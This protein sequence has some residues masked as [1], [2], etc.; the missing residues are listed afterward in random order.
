MGS[1]I[2][3]KERRQDF[4]SL[5]F[6]VEDIHLIV[7]LSVLFNACIKLGVVTN[8]FPYLVPHLQK[9][10]AEHVQGYSVAHPE[11]RVRDISKACSYSNS[12]VWNILHTT[13]GHRT[14]PLR[15]KEDTEDVSSELANG[16]YRLPFLD[17]TSIT[18]LLSDLE[19]FLETGSAGRRQGQGRRGA[20]TPNEYRYLVLTARRHRKMNATLLQ[21]H[22]RSA[23][24]TTVSTQTVRNRLHGVGMYADRPIVCVRLTSRHRPV[25]WEW[26]TEHVNWRRNEWS[27]S[28]F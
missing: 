21:Q 1:V 5:N 16:D 4:M 19:P 26:A 15:V 11:S 24:G 27:N 9:I 25:R 10:S 28:F 22:L 6:P 8:V 20:T 13:R 12:T 17:E 23:T 2:E 18:L 7:R 14:A 3:V